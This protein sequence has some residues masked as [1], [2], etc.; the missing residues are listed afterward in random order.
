MGFW[1]AIFVVILVTKVFAKHLMLYAWMFLNK[2]YIL[3]Q[4]H[5][6]NANRRRLKTGK[7]EVVSWWKPFEDKKG[8]D[9]PELYWVLACGQIKSLK[10]IVPFIGESWHPFPL[11]D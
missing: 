7:T 2:A 1:S 5:F 6:S 3:T 10:C 8:L 4:I 9:G 11:E